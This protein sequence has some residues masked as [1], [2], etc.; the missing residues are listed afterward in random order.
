MA[1]IKQVEPT[2]SAPLFE[3]FEA[4]GT[5]VPAISMALYEHIVDLAAEKYDATLGHIT[6][7]FMEE[8]V[9]KFRDISFVNRKP[10]E[11]EVVVTQ[12]EGRR[13]TF[14]IRFDLRGAGFVRNALLEYLR[15]S[16]PVNSGI[17]VE[18]ENFVGD[19]VLAKEPTPVTNIKNRRV[20]YFLDD[21]DV[22]PLKPRPFT[23]EML[24]K[25]ESAPWPDASEVE[26]RAFHR[27]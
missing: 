17:R 1:K 25:D 22:K 14:W 24:P 16:L 11:V 12:V 5:S 19:V 6:P 9:N 3:T 27:R 21:W 18:S 13:V 20:T 2:W 4:S 8:T 7:K 26:L 23:K 10:F 15:R